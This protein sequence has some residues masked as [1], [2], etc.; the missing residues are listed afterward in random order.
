LASEAE[1]THDVEEEHFWL[2]RLSS[3]PKG[4]IDMLNSRACRSAI[5]FN[6]ELSVTQCEALMSDLSKCAF[7]FM[8]AHGRVSMVPLSV[9]GLVPQS[10]TIAS[11][12]ED[13]FVNAFRRWTRVDKDDSNPTPMEP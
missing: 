13:G 4:I 5:M 3:C 10:P 9:A 8:C 7:P 2:K 1:C 12:V 6:D 11:G